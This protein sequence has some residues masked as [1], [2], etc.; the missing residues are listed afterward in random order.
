MREGRWGNLRGGSFTSVPIQ[1]NQGADGCNE[2]RNAIEDGTKYHQATQAKNT[3]KRH[4]LL[5][6]DFRC[7]DQRD[8]EA[9][10]DCI[11]LSRTHKKTVSNNNTNND[12][13]NNDNDVGNLAQDGWFIP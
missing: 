3:H 8:R 10:H 6:W 5:H 11:A 12:N 9:E 13:D 2:I 4:F 1:I 7:D